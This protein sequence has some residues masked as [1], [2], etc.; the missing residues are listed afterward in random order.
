MSSDNSVEVTGET[1]EA[2]I[3]KGLEALGAAPYEVI[4]EVLEE[5]SSGI[6]GTGAREAKVRLKRLSMQR[7]PMPAYEPPPPP[8]PPTPSASPPTSAPRSQPTRSSEKPPERRAEPRGG[9]GERRGNPN[10]PPPAAKPNSGNTPRSGQSPARRN[11]DRP[12]RTDQNR[13]ASKPRA[14]RPD[15][16]NRRNR[17]NDEVDETIVSN[18]FDH[19][20][21]G[22]SDEEAPLFIEAELV[23]LDQQDDEAQVGKVVLEELLSRMALP[24]Q[25]EIRRSPPSQEGEPTP[26]VLNIVETRLASRLVGRRGETLASLQYLTRLITSRELQRRAELIVDVDSY[27]GKR[28]ASLRAL[29]NRVA[30]DVV[31][32]QKTVTLEPMPPHERR[33]IHL[34][35]RERTDVTTRS[36]GEGSGRKVTIVPGSQI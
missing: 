28:A 29:A 8:P 31:Q 26:W 30:D 23:P 11:D 16:G 34:A 24:A 19:A 17:Q 18:A 22:V 25:V 14:D 12:A 6:F 15:Q 21:F 2:A 9:S 10:N 3:R 32:N 33:I 13:N 4:V 35:L 20:D 5:P 1:I 27:K 36:M 7:P